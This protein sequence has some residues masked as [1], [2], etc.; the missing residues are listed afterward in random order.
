MYDTTT[1]NVITSIEKRKTEFEKK[2]IVLTFDDGPSR[3]L[4]QILDCLLAED[5]QAAF[6]WQSKLLHYKRPWKRV[7]EEGHVIGTHTCKHPNLVRMTRQ[8]QLQE[9]R[10]SKEK[11][12][13]ITGAEVNYF[14]PPFGQYNSDT[15][16]VANKL[17]LTTVMWRVASLDWELK[18][19]PDKIMSYVLDNLEDGAIILLH[20]LRQTVNVLPDLIKEIKKNGYDLTLFDF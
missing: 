7:I 17:Q 14:R 4:D 9:L 19:N 20:E 2:R 16:K 18:D 1:D 11:I 5:V 15:I 10:F 12:E 13:R 3:V 6:F 8:Q